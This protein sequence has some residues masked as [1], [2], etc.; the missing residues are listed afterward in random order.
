[1]VDNAAVVRGVYEA[2]AKGDVSELLEVLDEKIEWHEAEHVTY[3]PGGA[4]IG[5]QAVL[6]GVIARIPNDFDGFSIDVER[7]S[8][9][10]NTVLVEASLSRNGACD[11]TAARCAGRARLGL[12]RRQGGALAAIH[13]YVAVRSTDGRADGKGRRRSGVADTAMAG[14]AG[15][16]R[17]E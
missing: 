16:Q 8:G 17:F 11:R 1:M 10:G 9:S 2:F 14:A 13:R 12:P 4:F 6:E 7:I 15:R 3:W 5:P